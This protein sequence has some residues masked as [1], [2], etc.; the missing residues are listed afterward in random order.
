M[1]TV[2]A[3]RMLIGGNDVAAPARA[4]VKVTKAATALPD[5][6]CLGLWI[7]TAGTLNAIDAMGNTLTNFPAKAGLMPIGIRTVLTSGTADDI[8]ALY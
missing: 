2:P 6:T 8:W 4:A 3:S 5:G 7:G 1:A